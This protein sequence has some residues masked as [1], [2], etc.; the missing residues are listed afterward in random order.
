MVRHGVDQPLGPDHLPEW[1][2]C[3][4]DAADFCLDEEYA[5]GLSKQAAEPLPPA[6][7]PEI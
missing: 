7:R 4:P 1:L 3:H 5:T 2:N 6:K